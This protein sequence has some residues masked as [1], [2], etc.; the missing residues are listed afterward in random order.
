MENPTY[1]GDAV[2][3]EHDGFG[4]WLRTGDHRVGHCIDKIYLEPKVLVALINF[5]SNIHKEEG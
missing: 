1:L 4:I 2:Y 3:A 5:S